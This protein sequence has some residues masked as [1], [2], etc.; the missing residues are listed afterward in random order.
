MVMHRQRLRIAAASAGANSGETGPAFHGAIRQMRWLPTTPD[1]GADLQLSLLP[2]S[3]DTGDGWTF[4]SQADCL[5]VQ[6]TKCPM[7]PM[8][9]SDGQPDPADTGS[10]YGVPIFGAGDRIRAKAIA[11]GNAAITGRLLIW[12]ES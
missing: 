8:H 1:T 4:F 9:G 2:L 7:Q 3:G 5:G 11:G 6:F 10:A 12:T